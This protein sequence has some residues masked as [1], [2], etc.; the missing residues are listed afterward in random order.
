MKRH[1]QNLYPYDATTLGIRG[2]YQT[3]ANDSFLVNAP[4]FILAKNQVITVGKDYILFYSPNETGIKM[5]DV[6]L[7]DCYYFDSIIH[8]IVQDI[9]SHRVFTISQYMECPEKD[10]T[11]WVFVD[12]DY[13][14]DRLDAK[15][16][17]DY[18]GDC[19]ETEN[20]PIVKDNPRSNDDLL[21]FEF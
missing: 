11:K 6:T 1:A 3:L 7:V 18:C 20:K 4:N 14:I 15:A 10:C 17:K 21:E 5:L 19:D 2:I 13:F 9:R 12:L 8:L 16:I